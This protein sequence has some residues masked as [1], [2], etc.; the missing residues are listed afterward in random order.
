MRTRARL[1]LAAFVLSIAAWGTPRAQDLVAALDEQ[2]LLFSDIPSVF[3]ASK[4]EQKTTDAPSSVS[5]VTSEEIRRYGYRTL[6]DVLASLRSLVISYDRNYSYVGGRGFALPGDYNSRIL[7]LVDGMRLNDPV[8]SQGLIGTEFLLDVDL[9]DRIEFVRGPASSL[10][11]A[12]ALFGVVNIV[13]KRGRDLSGIEAVAQAASL[14]TRQ[15]RLSLGKRYSNGVEVLA[16]A[17]A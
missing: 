14:N 4:F 12:D 10:Y 15:A 8:Y 5:I 7:F 6:K 3:T 9:I 2:A 11:G 13:T 17:T 1:S 16:S